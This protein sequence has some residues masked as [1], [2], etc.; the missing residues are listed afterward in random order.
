[1]LL[2]SNFCKIV[3]KKKERGSKGFDASERI[4]LNEMCRSQWNV[5]YLA[6]VFSGFQPKSDP[7]QSVQSAFF[8]RKSTTK[9]VF[10]VAQVCLLAGMMLAFL[11]SSALAKPKGGWL[12]VRV[13][14]M[15]PSM[16]EDFSLGNRFGLLVVDVERDSPADDAGLREDDVILSFDG[17]ATDQVTPF[18]A[19]VRRTQPGTAVKLKIFRDGNE[20]EL[21]VDIGRRRRHDFGSMSWGTNDFSFGFGG[22]LLGVQVVTLNGDLAPY[23]DRKEGEGVLITDVT[24]DGPAQEAGLK[25]G[26]VITKVDETE[27]SDRNELVETLSEYEAG[28]EVTIEF[29][30]K[31]K[32]ES[33]AVT[34]E[35]DDNFHFGR[36]AIPY[37]GLRNFDIDRRHL[38]RGRRVRIRSSRHRSI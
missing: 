10:R 33:V 15:T 14:E 13:A 17:Q 21:Q 34:L 26:D 16:R 9:T 11:S 32:T 19:A 7:C 31:R 4:G 23:F 35:E 28:D 18:T 8:V 1:M 37:H 20:R 6:H 27:V 22:P 30:R 29:V 5:Q 24:E 2:S 3:Q 36:F 25:A 12:G 38:P